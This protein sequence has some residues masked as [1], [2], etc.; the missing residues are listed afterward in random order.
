MKRVS[1]K[2][3]DN[4]SPRQ[5]LARQSAQTFF[6]SVGRNAYHQLI[7][8]VFGKFAFERNSRGLIYL[9]LSFD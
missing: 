3:L 4:H 6:I 2:E 7:A 1:K 5:N 8:E 9:V